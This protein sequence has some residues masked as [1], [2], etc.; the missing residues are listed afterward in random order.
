[1]RRVG[2]FLLLVSMLLCVLVVGRAESGMD[3]AGLYEQG[4]ACYDVGLFAQALECFQACPGYQDSNLWAMFCE[5][6]IDVQSG[7]IES[8]ARR[9]R[10]VFV[11]LTSCQFEAANGYE[12]YCVGRYY[13]SLGLTQGAV[14]CYAQ[15]LP[16]N[17]LDTSAR[18]GALMGL[19]TPVP[20]PSATPVPAKQSFQAALKREVVPRRGPGTGYAKEKKI[21]S[22]TPVVFLEAE[23]APDT[24]SLWGLI[25]FT[26]DDGEKRAWVN[27]LYISTER[28]NYPIARYDRRERMLTRDAEPLYGPGAEFAATGEKLPTGSRVEVL[29]EELDYTMIEYESPGTGERARGWVLTEAFE[30][31]SL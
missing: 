17:I 22:D 30:Q 23:Q 5:A 9:D 31:P 3:Y 15:I 14:D 4:I 10:D 11:Y 28:V 27:M 25:Q 6:L 18:Y 7:N 16:L 12:T 26:E 1:M 29:G 13:E 21:P 19:F 8:I 20:T 24:G 2:R